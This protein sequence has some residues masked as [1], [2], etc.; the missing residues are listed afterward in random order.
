MASPSRISTSDGG[1][2]TPMVAAALTR[3][4]ARP[5]GSSPKRGATRR[6]SKAELEATEP[7]I[8]ANMFNPHKEEYYYY[9]PVDKIFAKHFWGKTYPQFTDIEKGAKLA[10]DWVAY[11][12]APVGT[13]PMADLRAKHGHPKPFKVKYWELDNELFR[14]FNSPEELAQAA[15]IYSKAMHA[16]DPSIKTGL[17][18]Y[19][20]RLSAGTAKMLEIAGKDIGFLADRGPFAGNTDNKVSLIRQYNASHGTSI[21]YADT[22]FFV[23]PDRY[24]DSLL[25]QFR[26]EKNERNLDHATWAYGLNTAN[27]L[28]FWQRYGGDMA[29]SCFNSFVNDHLHSPFDTPKNGVLIKYPGEV[30]SLFNRSPARWP[31]VPDGYR[32]DAAQPFQAQ[33]AWDLKRKQLV[34]YVYNATPEARQASFD[35]HLL[36]SKFKQARAQT[37]SAPDPLQ[38]NTVKEPH[39]IRHGITALI[40]HSEENLS[41]DAAPFSFTE[42]VVE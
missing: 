20:S 38:V 6:E 29:F 31:L 42:V 2:T 12:N 7:F 13:H 28:M 21:Q 22:E 19:G 8:G 1:T 40:L 39:P 32:P 18:T 16:V 17:C 34:I 15:V 37:L 23:V 27:L 9:D 33:A 36:P 25:N 24:S 4:V 3:A 30:Y 26:K 14:W 41:V 10:A 5:G 35:L 11:C